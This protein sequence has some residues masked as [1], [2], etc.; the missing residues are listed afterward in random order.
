MSLEILTGSSGAGKSHRIYKEVIEASLRHPDRQ[1]LVMVPEQFTM[2]TQKELVRMHP[3][4]GLLNVDV[5]SF[6]RLAWRVFGEVGGSALPVLEEIGKSL[7]VQRVTA[8]LQK[9]LHVLG[10]TLSR[11]GSVSRMKSLISELLQYG[12]LPEDMAA[13]QEELGDSL[14]ARKLEDI[15]VVYGAFRDYL[16]DHYLTTEEVPEVLCRVIGRSSL[17]RGSTVILDGFTGF[18]PVQYKVLRELLILAEDVR[19]LVTIDPAEDPF[20]RGNP[21]QL[22]QMSREMV[23][24]M[25]ELA[26]ETHTEI[27]PVRPVFAGENSRFSG[28][29]PLA[30]LEQNLFRYRRAAY[31]EEPVCEGGGIFLTEAADPKAELRDILSQ[32][33]RLTRQGG[34][35]Y[36][37]IALITGDPETYGEDAAEMFTAAGIPCFLDRKQAVMT[38]PLVECIRAALQMVVKSYTYDTVFRFLRSGMTRFTA[39]EIDDLENYVLALGIRGRT[40]YE[41]TWTKVPDYMDAGSVGYIDG[42]RQRFVEETE[43]LHECLHDRR[44]VLRKK[45]AALYQFLVQFGLQ[46]KMKQLQEQFEADGEPVRAKEYAQIYAAVMDLLDKVTEVLGEEKMGTAAFAEVLDAGFEEL[47]IGLLPP[48]EDQVMIGDMERTR[49]KTI[50]V[51]FFAGINEGVIPRPV[52]GGGILSE[53]DRETLERASVRLAPTAREEI[54]RQRFYLYLAM[55]KPSDALY[56]SYCRTGKDGQ[57]MLPSYLVGVMRQLFPKLTIR[58]EDG[59][60]GETADVLRLLETR[61]G[62]RQM[63]LSAVRREQE[64]ELSPQTRELLVW[65]RQQPGGKERLEHLLQA[66]DVR[67]DEDGIGAAAAE[68]LYGSVLTNS[69]TRLEQFAGCAFRHFCQYGLRLKERELYG[70]TPRDLGTVMHEALQRFS[71]TLR[72]EG[73]EWADLAD[74]ERIG[75]ADRALS[76]VTGTY[77][78]DVLLST[79]RNRW[80]SSGIREMLQR[81]VWALQTQIRHGSFRPSDFELAF[82][83][84]LTAARFRLSDTGSMRLRG[85]IDR[86]DLC[87]DDGTRYVKIIDYK[88]GSTAFDTGKLY[89]GLQLQLVLYLNAAMENEQRKH[90][91]ERTE[92]AG[93]FYYHIDDPVVDVDEPEKVPA[94]IL[95]KLRPDG[96]C[97]A[98]KQVLQLLDR[99]LVRTGG[100]SE[101]IPVRLNKDGTPSKTSSTADG[102]EFRL[103]SAYAGEKTKELGR[104]ILQGETAAHPVLYGNEDA[105]AWCAFHAVCGFDEKIPGYTHLRCLKKDADELRKD[106]RSYLEDKR[107]GSWQ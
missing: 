53:I 51:L 68:L 86:V 78:N 58:R 77:G 37:D 92:P 93:I 17:V 69:A 12:V 47:H 10:R 39:E 11:Q 84:D 14:L 60:A 65:L 72:E 63:L 32:I 102:E 3:R 21:H 13:W 81:T 73:R 34:Y 106:M 85:R 41:K 45:T 9:D 44:A 48:G 74:E 105:C 31:G 26:Q 71:E 56:L 83:D 87:V 66:A 35:R 98:E 103:F 38:N 2:Q 104:R 54:C 36:R 20:R 43:H 107:D 15:R 90:P 62:R 29:A 97:R 30:F 88:T 89:Y 80:L 22:F 24:R 70:F 7:I 42:L 101:V 91:E 57:T 16:E 100:V 49:L 55:T 96:R 1:Y 82:S 23:C 64:T 33:L 4:H 18:T 75:Y 99:E 6:N 46:E 94:K 5:L 40:M 25:K 67:Q 50:R 52:S 8:G 76:E 28:N 19:L 59:P 79:A 27:L 95:E 61:E